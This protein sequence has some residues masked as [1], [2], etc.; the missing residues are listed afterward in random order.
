MGT[1]F[2]IRFLERFCEYF[3]LVTI[4]RKGGSF[5]DREWRVKVT[6]LF[7]SMFEWKL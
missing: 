2:R 1:A 6:P 3:G 4:Q 5:D 7:E